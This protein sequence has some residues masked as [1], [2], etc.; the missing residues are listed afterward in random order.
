MRPIRFKSGSI[1]KGVGYDKRLKPPK[2]P[3]LVPKK[4]TT[5]EKTGINIK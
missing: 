2:D 1:M 3:T 5:P 4:K